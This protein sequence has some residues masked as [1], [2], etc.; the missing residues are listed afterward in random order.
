[1]SLDD[2]A[3]ASPADDTADSQDPAARPIPERPRLRS[4]EAFPADVQGQRVLCLRDPSNMSEAVLAFSEDAVPILA[5]LDGSH[6]I[7]DIQVAE[8]QRQGRIVMRSEIEE[9]VRTL[10]EALFLQSPRF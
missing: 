7:L 5:A 10:D 4:I 6:S 1:M 2:Q 9:V 8:T 3:L